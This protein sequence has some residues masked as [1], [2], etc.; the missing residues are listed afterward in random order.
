MLKNSTK[1]KEWIDNKLLSHATDFYVFHVKN[2]DQLIRNNFSSKIDLQQKG[3]YTFGENRFYESL[4]WTPNK[5][6]LNLKYSKRFVAIKGN[7]NE[8]ITTIN[9]PL[10]VCF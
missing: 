10:I 5:E 3:P 8:Q 4:N 7:L 9:L 6:N 2:A 1:L